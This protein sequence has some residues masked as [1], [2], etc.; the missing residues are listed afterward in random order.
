[1]N[2]SRIFPV[3]SASRPAT[4][5]HGFTLIELLVVIAIIAILAGMLL[6]ALA[7]A[8]KKAQSTHCSNNMRQLALG[9]KLYTSDSSDRLINNL[10]SSQQSWVLGNE[11]ISATDGQ[12]QMANTNPLTLVDRDFIKNTAPFGKHG[13][14]ETLGDNVG[15]NS[16]VFKC[17]ADK[18]YNRATR[19][20]RVR[21]VAMNQA[22]GFNVTAQ[23][24]GDKEN[25]ATTYKTFKREADIDNPGPSQLFVFVDEH[26][27]SLNDGGFA[28][29]MVHPNH[30]VDFPAN[31]HNNASSFAFADGH[32][33][34]HRWVDKDTLAIINYEASGPPAQPFTCPNDAKWLQDRT[35]AKR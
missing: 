32:T 24:L 28:V 29:C 27:A 34:I 11:N 30:I 22:V 26:P 31:Y 6:P 23:W 19:V 3:L 12:T 7:S 21:S 14:N 9:W 25:P 5:R 17:T 10:D 8:K 15:K 13:N 35:S 2:A 16:L 20:A 1:M 18:S 33:E 4:P